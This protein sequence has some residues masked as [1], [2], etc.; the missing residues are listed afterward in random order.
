MSR[1]TVRNSDELVKVLDIAAGDLERSRAGV[2]R[3]AVER[4]I[5]DFDDLSVANG[6]LRDPSDPVLDRDDVRRDLL[7]RNQGRRGYGAGPNRGAGTH[8]NR[9]SDRWPR[10][11]LVHGDRP[12]G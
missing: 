8:A 7:G 12:E 9:R 3:Q 10:R 2:M 4:Y 11:E 1:V 5:E 6:R